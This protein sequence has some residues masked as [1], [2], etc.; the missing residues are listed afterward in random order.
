MT[1]KPVL[2]D[3]YARRVTQ[4]TAPIELVRA[5]VAFGLRAGFDVNQILESADVSPML[6]ADGRSRVTEDQIAR[7]VQ[8]LWRSTDDELFGLGAT[9]LPRGS[10]RLLCFGMLSAGTLGIALE[11]LEG[12]VEAMPALPPV[13]LQVVDDTARIVVA[14]PPRHDPEGLFSTMGLVVVHRVV[15]WAIG[16]PVPLTRVRLP[17]SGPL[18]A[19][20]Y[21]ML[22]GR[23]AEVD[24]GE[25]VLELPG[26]LLHAPIVRD[27]QELEAFV[28][29]MPSGLLRRPVGEVTTGDQVRRIFEH[30]LRTQAMPSADEV[31][32]Q[33]AVSA[34]TLRRKLGEEGTSAREIREELLRDAAVTSLVQ[35][36]ES[37]ADLSDR[38]G[39]SEPSAFTRAFRRWT[40][41]TPGAYRRGDEDA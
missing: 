3:G 6:L 1:E 41:S 13:R 29:S 22:W 16:R 15:S 31:A 39:F 9:P 28:A 24:T 38:L 11:R 21:R 25:A 8:G 19:E 7:V 36:E 26:A 17:R 30:G 37:V 10:F 32:R 33:L 18:G 35:G 14:L 2:L 23:A 12:F 4:Q 40:G 20:T 27:D 34:Q 5:A